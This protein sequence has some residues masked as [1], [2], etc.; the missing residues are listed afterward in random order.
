VQA[1]TPLSTECRKR[2]S[3]PIGRY[4]ITNPTIALFHED[5]RHIART[6]PT[7]AFITIDSAAFDGNKLADV[8]WDDKKVMMFTQDLRARAKRAP[9]DSK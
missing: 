2:Q 8:T 4:R 1:R 7:G 3:L 9:E 6:V 5:G